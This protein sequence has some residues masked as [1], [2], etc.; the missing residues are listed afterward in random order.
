[1]EGAEEL[2]RQ[3]TE[4]GQRMAIITN[5][6]KEVQ[7]NRISRSSLYDSFECII[8]SEDAGSQSLMKA[9][10]IMPLIS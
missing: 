4:R 2:C 5:G 7:F 8:V 1:M 10:S 9:Y 6:I 3:L